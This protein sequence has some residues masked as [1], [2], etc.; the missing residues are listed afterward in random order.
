[1][2]LADDTSGMNTDNT[3]LNALIGAIATVLLSFTGISPVLG[4]ALAGYLEGGETGDG[5]RIGALSGLIASLPLAV[6]VVLALVVFS[7]G[8][9]FGVAIGGG[10]LVLAIVA[11]AIGYTVA[12]SALGGVAGIY[13]NK[14]L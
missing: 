12:L 6:V 9:D 3:Y 1:M 14:E 7:L 2:S 10:L 4:G 5:L 11:V 8:G 13:L